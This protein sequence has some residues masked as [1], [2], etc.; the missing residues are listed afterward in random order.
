MQPKLPS[1]RHMP[2]TYPELLRESTVFFGSFFSM[3]RNIWFSKYRRWLHES[4]EFRDGPVVAWFTSIYIAA[5]VLIGAACMPLLVMIYHFF[6]TGEE[7]AI[8]T[9][10]VITGS[11][12][13][14]G[15]M[16]GVW[17]YT[18]VYMRRSGMVVKKRRQ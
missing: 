18:Y 2:L 7:M 8:L 4:Y 5:V 16:Y 14:G 10:V 1:T 15:S 3:T 17:P 9:S 12:L 6:Y 13:V 11:A